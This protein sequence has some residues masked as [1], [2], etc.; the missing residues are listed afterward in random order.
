[1][2]A[3]VALLRHNTNYRFL[4]LARVISNLGDWFNLLA[5]AA[6][7]TAL[8]DAGTAISYLFLA[9]F[10]PVFFMSP[11]A[12][13]L[14]DRYDRR[15][16]MILADLLRAV[17]VLGFLF[18]RSPD[19]L[20]LLYLLTTVQFVLS[21]LYT[22]AHSAL[23]PN[24][25]APDEL[26]T[27]NALDSFTWSSMLAIGSLLGGLAAAFLGVQAAFVLDALTFLLSAWF[28][29]RMTR[30]PVSREVEAGRAGYRD[31]W[32]GLGYL[33][34]RPFILGLSLVKAAGALVWGAINVLELPLAHEI[35]PLAGDGALTLGLIYA[36]TGIG[37]GVGP[38]VLRAWLG[39][40]QRAGLWAISMSFGL[41]TLGVLGIGLAPSL[42]WV[43]GATLLRALGSGA[44]WVFS[45]ALLQYLVEDRF[46]GRVFAF[47]F[48][49]LTLT[50]SISTLWAGYAQ[51]RLGLSVQ[52]VFQVMAGLAA[53][54]GGGWLLFQWRRAPQTSGRSA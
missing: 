28:V 36:V 24:I 14:A 3:Y 41:L 27:A 1:M 21:S 8:S 19:Q 44:L 43:L 47:E 17:T 53:L 23:L 5:S 15:L 11:V 37:T 22:P 46:R 35:F 26:V 7:I 40:S 6:L 48:A 30:M 10:L 29:A 25:V 18:I 52:A 32:D 34:V 20:W 38:L 39:D 54:L 4:W 9:R 51:D 31:F 50:Q 2:N 13:V 49:V 16:L 45:S 12:G 42:G 33:R